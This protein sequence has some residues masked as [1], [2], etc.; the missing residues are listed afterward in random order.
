MAIY[1]YMWLYVA[2]C[3][4]TSN[5]VWRRVGYA[6]MNAVHQ[7]SDLRNRVGALVPR[8]LES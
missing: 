8:S 4:Y 1:S 6:G 3:G 2:V 5:T 7:F